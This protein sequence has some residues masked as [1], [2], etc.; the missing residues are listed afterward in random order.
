MSVFLMYCDNVY[1]WFYSYT[2]I[3]FDLFIIS[4][5]SLLFSFLLFLATFFFLCVLFLIPSIHM[6]D[7]FGKIT[8]VFNT[9]YISIP[10]SY[11]ETYI[12]LLKMLD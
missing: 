8:I 7:Y 5:L 9:G 4:F 10:N 11:D 12:P 3:S 1:I 2:L 6:P